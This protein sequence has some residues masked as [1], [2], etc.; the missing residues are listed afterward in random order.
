MI[1]LCVITL[2]LYKISIIYI[3][4]LI[5]IFQISLHLDDAVTELSEVNSITR[6]RGGS[7]SL[8]EED[9]GQCGPEGFVV[10]TAGKSGGMTCS[11]A[12]GGLC[13]TGPYACIAFTGKVCKDNSCSGV[14]ACVGSNIDFVKDGCK[15][16]FSC[17]SARL[18][19][20]SDSCKVS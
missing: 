11:D 13:C 7:P 19:M 4:S 14:F 8:S 3:F 15:G 5:C 6:L 20:V 9:L 12:C 18:S 16:G 10:C 2:I 17:Y 1:F